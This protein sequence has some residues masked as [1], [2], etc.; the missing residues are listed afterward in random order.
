MKNCKHIII[1]TAVSLALTACQNMKGR[2]FIASLFSDPE[3]EQVEQSTDPNGQTSGNTFNDISVPDFDRN[4]I[5]VLE[6]ARKHKIT[7]LDF[8]ASWCGP[9]MSEMHKGLGIIG[10]S[11]D[12]D[13]KRWKEATQANNMT[14]LQL[15][16][17]RGWDSEVAKVNGVQAIPHT[18][19]IDKNGNILATD[20]RGE[21]LKQ[22]VAEALKK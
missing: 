8:W 13:Y 4:P 9:C 7:I 5:S 12:S 14:W 15:S 17:L 21:D 20:L 6:E 11:L 3:P 2:D 10:L 1:L 22:F 19:I 18:I 16:E